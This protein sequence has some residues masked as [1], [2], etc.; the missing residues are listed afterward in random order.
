MDKWIVQ[1]IAVGVR[2]DGRGA[3]EVRR[4]QIESNV[5][6]SCASS[7][8]VSRG[9]SCV[10]AGVKSEISSPQGALMNEGTVVV[11]V[12]IVASLHDD[13][14]LR[15]IE[16]DLGRCLEA[17][18]G[19]EV[20]LCFFFLPWLTFFSPQQ[21]EVIDRK[22]LCIVSGSDG[23]AWTLFVDVVSFGNPDAGLLDS[24]SLAVRAALCRTKLPKI[25]PLR[26]ALFSKPDFTVEP[27]ACDA[28]WSFFSPYFFCCLTDLADAIPLN[29]ANVPVMVTV[30]LFGTIIV[31]VRIKYFVVVI[32]C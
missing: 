24:C 18:L 3:L 28:L 17:S 30:A 10:V 9:S 14:K 26:S 29:V 23:L 8:R 13:K 1:G 11:K 2:D 12:N 32:F 19:G 15:E 7:A 20:P 31:L 25:S 5:L 6:V 27:G 4:A 16:N 22:G 21:G